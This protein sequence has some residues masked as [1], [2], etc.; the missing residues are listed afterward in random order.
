MAD[1]IN[2]SS[3]VGELRL[4]SG[5]AAGA[6]SMVVSSTTGLPATPF[7]LAVDYGSASEEIVKVTVAAGT[8]LTVTRGYDGTSAVAHNAQA[9]IRHVITPEDLRLSRQHEAATSV[10]G[11]GTVVGTAETQTLSN[12]NLSS[13][14]NTFPATLVTVSGA[15]ALTSKSVDL[16]S[17]TLTGTRAQFNTAM[18]DDDFVSLTGTETLTNK[19]LTSGT[20]T[21]PSSLATLTGAQT[22]TNKT[23]T[24]PAMSDPTI[25]IS[26]LAGRVIAVCTSS[27]RPGS[28]SAGQVIFETDTKAYG[29]YDGSA[30]VMWDTAWQSYTPTWTGTGTNPSIGNGSILG[31]YMRKG[32]EVRCQVALNC[33]STT[34]FGSGT[35]L[36]GIPAGLTISSLG[37]VYNTIGTCWVVNQGVYHAFGAARVADATHVSL[38]ITS[39]GANYADWGATAPWTFKTT[40]QAS[41]DFNIAIT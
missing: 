3:T 14:T 26:S 22:L 41:T 12:K 40:D 8:T 20:N 25:T 6:T 37:T 35:Y 7:K 31:R 32:R 15:Q 23:L 34:T 4:T 1:S 9:V 24:A 13:G 16:G 33:G 21:F 36:F 30:W 29:I 19:N 17:N 27:T 28:P 39:G 11:V 18:T 38:N 2:Y 5:I 10:H